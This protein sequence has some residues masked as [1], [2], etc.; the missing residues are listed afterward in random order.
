MRIG[1]LSPFFVSRVVFILS[2]MKSQHTCLRAHH[3]LETPCACSL[4]VHVYRRI[5]FT[6]MRGLG[7]DF[8]QF[9]LVNMDA[10]RGNGPA[11]RGSKIGL[12]GH[13]DHLSPFFQ[14]YEKWFG[15]G[16]SFA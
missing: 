3:Y 7:L 5:V 8:H 12:A 16:V 4:D 15:K 2:C 6:T 1:S 13:P 10:I 14:Q 9:R 11:G